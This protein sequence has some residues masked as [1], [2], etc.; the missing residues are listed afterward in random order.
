MTNTLA[1]IDKFF[2]RKNEI[3][4]DLVNW[5]CYSVPFLYKQNIYHDEDFYN[6][7]DVRFRAI[8]RQ[9]YEDVNEYVATMLD[10]NESMAHAQ[11][12]KKEVFEKID[13]VGI[14]CNYMIVSKGVG[15]NIL[16]E[17][18]RTGSFSYNEDEIKY[19]STDVLID[20]NYDNKSVY[21]FKKSE[22]PRIIFKSEGVAFPN[23]TQQLFLVPNSNNLF[24]NVEQVEKRE[25]GVFYVGKYLELYVRKDF[26]CTKIE[27]ID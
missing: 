5:N 8:L 19:N 25:Q 11:C 24:S 2:F 16:S 1:N 15:L 6:W 12:N 27:I 9:M 21:I 23:L 26:Q 17:I 3:P 22:C 10:G 7:Y 20:N 13:N 14:D 18:Y 4:D